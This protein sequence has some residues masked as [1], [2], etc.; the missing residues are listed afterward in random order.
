MISSAPSCLNSGLR[1]ALTRAAAARSFSRRSAFQA[2]RN[3]AARYDA[4]R[5][6][7]VFGNGDWPFFRDLH[8]VSDK[9][10]NSMEDSYLDDV[11]GAT[12]RLIQAM[13]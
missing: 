9:S 4:R 13:N 6:T 12:A 2:E 8:D 10:K 1:L 7:D 5:D 3:L 11:R